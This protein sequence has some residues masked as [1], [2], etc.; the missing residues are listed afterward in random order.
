MKNGDYTAEKGIGRSHHEDSHCKRGL[1]PRGWREQRPRLELVKPRSL[2]KPHGARPLT[3]RRWYAGLVSLDLKEGQGPGPFQGVPEPVVLV[4]LHFCI[5]KTV[6][7]LMPRDKNPVPGGSSQHRRWVPPF[8]QPHSP[9]RSAPNGSKPEKQQCGPPGP[10]PASQSGQRT[11]GVERLSNQRRKQ[12]VAGW[13]H[14]G[15]PCPGCQRPACVTASLVMVVLTWQLLAQ[16]E[17]PLP[18]ILHSGMG[19]QGCDQNVGV[20]RRVKVPGRHQ[21]RDESLGRSD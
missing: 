2:E 18:R 17:T 6:S 1:W 5:G 4:A 19:P 8:P 11:V 7:Q 10:A 20:R 3:L 12:Q 9:V 15:D 21:L 14:R 13:Q 16:P